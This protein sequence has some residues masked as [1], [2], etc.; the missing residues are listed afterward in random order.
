[1]QTLF[2]AAKKDKKQREK[3]IDIVTPTETGRCVIMKTDV[4]E[5]EKII[6]AGIEK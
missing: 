4:D 6:A 2:E 5:L 1:M 3:S